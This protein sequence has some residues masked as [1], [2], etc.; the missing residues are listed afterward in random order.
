VKVILLDGEEA[1]WTNDDTGGATIPTAGQK[2]VRRAAGAGFFSTIFIVRLASLLANAQL[3]QAEVKLAILQAGNEVYSNVT[4]LSVTATDIYFS[5]SLGLGN[6][7]LKSLEPALQKRFHFDAAKAAEK[8]RQQAGANALYA[9]AVKQSKPA[10]PS[11][12][13]TTQGPGSD[14]EVPPHEIT[15]RSFLN[16]PSPSVVAEKWL[17]PQPITPGKF[18]LVDFWATWSGPSRAAIVELNQFY[19][20]FKDRLV[21][22]GLSDETEQEVSRMTEPHI[23]YSVAI[24]PQHRASLAFGVER[25]P[26]AVLVDPKGI[27]R[28]EG[29]PGYLD[30]KKLG[31]LLDKFA[32]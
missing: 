7:K 30:E 6:A 2:P 15:A 17:T 25:I 19:H 5:H 26:H 20:K 8:E 13:Q 16:Q 22:V 4:V 18:I 21:I 11:P 12:G 14:D 10:N 24:D 29:H 23:D 32:D 31:A 1:R 9:Q 27:V 28:F 3:A